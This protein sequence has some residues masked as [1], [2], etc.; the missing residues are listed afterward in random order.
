MT[1]TVVSLPDLVA[2][3]AGSGIVDRLAGTTPWV[4]AFLTG[5]LSA[6]LLLPA[7]GRGARLAGAALG[8]I[9]L[10]LICGTVLEPLASGG[11]QVIFW[12]LGGVALIAAAAAISARDPVYTA[13]WFALSLLGTAGLLFFEGA[14]F[15]A[16]ATVA[17]YAGAIVVTFLF[18]L[19]LAQPQGLA[20]YDRV[21]WGW[22]S[23]LASTVIASLLV[24][25]LTFAVKTAY[26]VSGMETG[27]GT[28][29]DVL[30]DAHMAR[31]GAE[32][33]SRHLLSVE[34][35]GT[36]LLIALVGALAIMIQSGSLPAEEREGS[37]RD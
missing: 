27:A 21:S 15:L 25:V 12:S 28:A 2:Q 32:L 17:V 37:I 22:Y 10:A 34:I 3:S 23:K 1:L 5:L 9:S 14:Q 18:V 33:F 26:S 29:R 31:F 8:V 24:G 30:A 20:T 19:M 35:G 4:W 7:G 6:L 13:I 16:V 11:E 36:L